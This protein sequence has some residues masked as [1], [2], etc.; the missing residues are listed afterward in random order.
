M[1]EQRH[2]APGIDQ[3][4]FDSAEEMLEWVAEQRANVQKRPIA[5]E[6]MEVKYGSYAVRFL[7]ELVIFCYVP[8][9]EDQP[10]DP[11][12]LD[13][14]DRKQRDENLLWVHAYSVR[15]AN[16]D[17][18]YTHRSVVWPITARTFGAAREANWDPTK[19]ND[20]AQFDLANSARAIQ[21]WYRK[22]GVTK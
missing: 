5:P 8:A 17:L 21:S 20:I 7:E 15:A 22:G 4:T 1:R 16:G 12:V 6:Q 3:V 10:E 18:G 9:L 11:E 14:I 13:M 19:M 2:V